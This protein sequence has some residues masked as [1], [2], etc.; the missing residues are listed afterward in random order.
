MSS[1]SLS[2][3]PV[4]S[5]KS[6]RSISTIRTAAAATTTRT[7]WRHVSSS[8]LE[9]PNRPR[10]PSLRPTTRWTFDYHC[11]RCLS[12][13]RTLLTET[14]YPLVTPKISKYRVDCNTSK[15]IKRRKKGNEDG[16]KAIPNVVRSKPVANPKKARQAA[17]AATKEIIRKMQEAEASAATAAGGGAPP[18]ATTVPPPPKPSASFYSRKPSP[19]KP[20]LSTSTLT[21]TNTQSSTIEPSA[22]EPAPRT[23]EAVVPQL[24]LPSLTL[25][26]ARRIPADQPLPDLDAVLSTLAEAIAT[27]PA[28]ISSG[29]STRSPLQSYRLP[30]PELTDQSE[31][32]HPTL[33]PLPKMA[34]SIERR[35]SQAPQRIKRSV[36]RT[37]LDWSVHPTIQPNDFNTLSDLTQITPPRAAHPVKSNSF[38]N[39]AATSGRSE[40]ITN[41]SVTSTSTSTNATAASTSDEGVVKKRYVSRRR[42]GFDDDD[43]LDFKQ[44]PYHS[45]QSTT[46][47]LDT[48]VHN[49]INKSTNT[50][51]NPWDISAIRKQRLVSNSE[52]VPKSVLLKNPVIAR[53]RKQE[54]ETEE[55]AKV[56]ASTTTTS[57]PLQS[58]LPWRKLD[59]G[60]RTQQSAIVLPDQPLLGSW[61]DSPSK[62]P[63]KKADSK[64]KSTY[65]EYLFSP[66]SVLPALR[67]GLRKPYELLYTN[68][69]IHPRI[70]QMVI[71]CVET[72]SEMGLDVVKTTPERLDTLLGHKYHQG[73][74]LRASY[75]PRALIKCLGTVSEDNNKYDLHFIRG[76]A[77]P[78]DRLATTS[79]TTHMVKSG[80]ASTKTPRASP[81][82]VWVVLD[83]VQTVYDMGH[84]LST[85][86]HLGI[87]G[88]IIKEKG[89]VLPH[90]DVSA[91]SE[92]TLERRPAYAVRTLVKF[93]KESQANGWQVIGLKAAYGSKRLIPF[94]R[95]PKHGVDQPTILIV[96]GSEVG[97]TKSAERQCDSFIHVPGLSHTAMAFGEVASL[98]VPVIS[99]IAIS[100]LVGGRM[101]DAA[102][103]DGSDRKAGGAEGFDSENEE[104]I[105]WVGSLPQWEVPMLRSKGKGN[106]TS[107]TRNDI[108]R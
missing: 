53:D 25:P 34:T 51:V 82:P 36:Y 108:R 38:T 72:A 24:P 27:Q 91:L 39:V 28:P 101:A 56:T 22:K 50:Q 73:V 23:S 75:L 5:I 81:P 67:T 43:D 84:I 76:T 41:N 46:Q 74:L 19:L 86:H 68:S 40:R 52:S 62:E 105:P 83:E 57:K 100:K 85:A 80:I 21:A 64:D 26:H 32:R 71:E 89:A 94:Y 69:N 35:P 16:K 55:A 96:G 17:E 47:V 97:I 11:C 48:I 102:G 95:F 1:T 78:F 58:A 49:R 59:H 13:T 60:D 8:F 104:P 20:E 87:D 33:D 93:I 2:L 4:R 14:P 12:T 3:A 61:I 44:R 99:G 90:A 77:K 54:R 65:G 63:E 18:S 6:I 79:N 107:H 37:I 70:S 98:P 106:Q 15:V 31:E 92:G 66:K 30:L 29:W 103:S 7:P 88:I 9:R 45:G 10:V 42:I